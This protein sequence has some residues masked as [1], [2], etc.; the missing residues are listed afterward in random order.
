MNEEEIV[1]RIEHLRVEMD[2]LGQEMKRSSLEKMR[3]DMDGVILDALSE[4]GREKLERE[5]KKLRGMSKCEN[6]EHCLNTVSVVATEAMASYVAGETERALTIITSL[7][8]N[9]KGI[10]SPC[11]D[12]G[13]SEDCLRLMD[14][15]RERIALSEKLRLATEDGISQPMGQNVSAQDVFHSLDPLSHPARL[16]VLMTLSTGDLSFTEVSGS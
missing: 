12:A 3:T 4:N 10:A 2:T 8:E 13:C 9:I 7:E 1:R 6:R 5:L 14:D 16:K 11:G 15:V